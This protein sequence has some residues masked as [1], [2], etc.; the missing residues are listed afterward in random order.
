MFLKR[1]P[2]ISSFIIQ[3]VGCH[4]LEMPIKVVGDAITCE[5]FF[6]HHHMLWP[7]QSLRPMH[8]LHH[9][10]VSPRIT[11]LQ[12]RKGETRANYRTLELL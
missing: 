9:I 1:L 6:W 4:K 10:Q 5:F 7:S 12:T 8:F 2:C 3:L 11:R